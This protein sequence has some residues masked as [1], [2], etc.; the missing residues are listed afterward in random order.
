[1]DSFK[2]I[3]ISQRVRPLGAKEIQHEPD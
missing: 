2:F 3:Q 1:V